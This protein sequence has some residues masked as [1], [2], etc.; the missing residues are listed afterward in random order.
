MH[1]EWRLSSNA[2]LDGLVGQSYRFHRDNDYLPESGLEDNVSDIVARVVL[3]PTPL[4]NLTYRTRLSHKDL[5][6]RMIDTTASF[7]TPKL[8][9][10]GGYLYANTDPYVLYD[11]PS[12]VSPTLNPPAGYFTPRQEVTANANT[13][14]GGWSVGAGVERNLKTGRFD[15]ASFN[16]GWQNDCFG[17]NV[18]FFERFT[19]FNLDNGDTTVLVQFTFKTLG[20]VG[21]SAL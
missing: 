15:S 6:A 18:I 19:S 21:F 9:F 12:T 4:F 14:F 20:N 2:S 13:V 16:G 8:N 1:S 11:S 17:T 7:G 5:G 10:S 3:T